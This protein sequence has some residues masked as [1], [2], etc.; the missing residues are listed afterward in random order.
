MA[1]LMPE[2]LVTGATGF[3]GKAVMHRLLTENGLRTV[4]VAVRRDVQQWIARVGPHVAG[5][6]EPTAG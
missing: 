5:D 1:F 3:I 6:L 4:A 2:V